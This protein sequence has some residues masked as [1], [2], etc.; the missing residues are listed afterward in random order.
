MYGYWYGINQYDIYLHIIE[1]T[2]KITVPAYDIFN[3]KCISSFVNQENCIFNYYE[4]KYVLSSLTDTELIFLE[5]NRVAN[6]EQKITFVRIKQ[7]EYEE[8]SIVIDRS[9]LLLEPYL[10]RFVGNLQFVYNFQ[11]KKLL[12]LKRIVNMKNWINQTSE[13]NSVLSI[14]EWIGN[15]FLHNGKKSIPPNLDAISLINYANEHNGY[16]NC[17]G[18][19]IIANELCLSIG[20]KSKFIICRQKELR[21]DNSHYMIVVYI[22][23]YGKWIAFDPT[24][25]LMFFDEYNHL[26]SLE[27]VRERLAYHKYIKLYDKLKYNQQ[28]LS[29]ELYTKSLL[30]KMYRFT[31]PI[32]VH[33]GYDEKDSLITLVPDISVNYDGKLIDCP[34]EFWKI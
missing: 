13:V 6:C 19:A 24:Y 2:V 7:Q 26:L 23:K 11:D 15:H 32:E 16:L 28:K 9:Q 33:S 29:K 3:K 25:N 4:S 8:N 12:C 14:L 27:Q 17:R 18:L 20:L 10:R 5:Y 1:H 22:E 31:S 30:V 34:E 21:C